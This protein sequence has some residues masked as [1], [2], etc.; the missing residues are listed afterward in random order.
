MSSRKNANE[1]ETESGKRRKDRIRVREGI[2][3][4]NLGQ[5]ERYKKGLDRKLNVETRLWRT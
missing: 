4:K 2:R 3:G 5:E 1:K